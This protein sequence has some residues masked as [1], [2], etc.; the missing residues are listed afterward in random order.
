MMLDST[1]Q[2]KQSRRFG[3]ATTMVE[4]STPFEPT[5]RR[6]FFVKGV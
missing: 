3:Q 4:S 1:I 5:G 2:T 6:I